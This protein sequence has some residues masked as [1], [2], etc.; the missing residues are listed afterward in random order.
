[1]LRCK[2][3]KWVIVAEM[4]MGQIVREVKRVVDTPDKVFL[5]NQVDG[6]FIN[7]TAI[8]NVLKTIK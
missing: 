1:M 7:P 4:N 3:V 6:T 2:A 5:A 8:L